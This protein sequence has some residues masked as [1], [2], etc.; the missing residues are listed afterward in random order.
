MLPIVH[1]YAAARFQAEMLNAC[2]PEYRDQEGV[3]VANLGFTLLKGATNA[4]ELKTSDLLVA[5]NNCV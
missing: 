2:Y 3:V 5:E 1:L 4:N